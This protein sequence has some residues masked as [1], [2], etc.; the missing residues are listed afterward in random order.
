M[1]EPMDGPYRNPAFAVDDPD[2]LWAMVGDIGAAH[3][4]T[5]HGADGFAS[6]MVPLLPVLRSDGTR[7]L[8]GHLSRANGHW[9]LIGSA[10]V[11]A[12]AIFSGPDGYISPGDYV[13]KAVDPRVVPTWNYVLVQV[14]GRLRIHD[15][16]EWVDALIRGL[17][18]RHEQDRPEP[19]S[20]DDAP[21]DYI[22]SR[23]RAIVGLELEVT[24]LAGTS[25]LSQ[26]KPD[27]DRASVAAALGAADPRSRRLAAAMAPPP[28][29]HADA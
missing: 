8:L 6:T 14:R 25:K 13:G 27:E 21:P 1:M 28:L 23:V 11:D 19:W 17:T 15:D 20:V 10:G 9:R 16:P 12:L 3:V 24:S 26:N 18:D 22:A 29:G 4:V 7:A 2:E 5:H